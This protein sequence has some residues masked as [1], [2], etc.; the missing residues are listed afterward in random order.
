M[1]LMT[2][3]RVTPGSACPGLPL[4]KAGINALA[5]AL[6]R[7][8]LADTLFR[9]S[10]LM[11]SGLFNTHRRGVPNTSGTAT[12]VWQIAAGEIPPFQMTIRVVCLL[13]VRASDSRTNG[14]SRAAC[15]GAW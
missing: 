2:S 8:P 7:S 12:L 15:S 3:L 1:V 9:L 5:A 14:P 4:S 6:D 13:A 10:G 11:N